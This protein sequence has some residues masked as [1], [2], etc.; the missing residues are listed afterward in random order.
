LLRLGLEFVRELIERYGNAL[1]DGLLTAANP[2]AT[3]TDACAI[4]RN[5][6][7]TQSATPKRR[8]HGA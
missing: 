6:R 3:V 8:C 1:S 2:R 4:L 5:S 7:L